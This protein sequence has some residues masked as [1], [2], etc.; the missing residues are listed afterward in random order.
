M[1]K[2]NATPQV[3]PFDGTIACV[4]AVREFLQE[5]NYAEAERYALSAR[6]HVARVV[7]I[8]RKA[9]L[10]ARKAAK[11]AKQAERMSEMWLCDRCDKP[12]TRGALI[13]YRGFLHCADCDKVLRTLD[14]ERDEREGY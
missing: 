14:A 12:F 1:A 8:C 7:A 4:E 9:T 5:G 10:P 3:D 13:K 2:R 6:F 11:A